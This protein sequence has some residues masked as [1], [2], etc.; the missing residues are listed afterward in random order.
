[1]AGHLEFQQRQRRLLE[2]GEEA[3]DALAHV[4]AE[5]RLGQRVALQHVAQLLLQVAEDQVE[6][7]RV[8]RHGRVD[9]ED[10]VVRHGLRQDM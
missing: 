1:L 2:R 8:D 6:L 10:A 3:L 7:L 4:L 5:A 9:G